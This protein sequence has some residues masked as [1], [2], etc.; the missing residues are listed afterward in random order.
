MDVEDHVAE[1]ERFLIEVFRDTPDIAG[2]DGFK[3]RKQRTFGEQL[4]DGGNPAVDG[5]VVDEDVGVQGGV[6]KG[7]HLDGHCGQGVFL[8]ALVERDI[9]AARHTDGLGDIVAGFADIDCAGRRDVEE[10]DGLARRLLVEHGRERGDEVIII[11]AGRVLSA[12]QGG[13][14]LQ[15]LHAAQRLRL[16]A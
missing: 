3:I 14:E 9:L 10:R 11:C 16:V 12:E 13:I 7:L 4:I 1:G 5:A 8:A 6:V 2:L 15:P